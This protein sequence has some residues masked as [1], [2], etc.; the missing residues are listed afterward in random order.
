MLC[1]FQNVKNEFFFFSKKGKKMSK[2]FIL[3]KTEISYDP[4][5]YAT[6]VHRF[7]SAKEAVFYYISHCCPIEVLEG[8]YGCEWNVL[9]TL[10]VDN[11]EEVEEK[12]EKRLKYLEEANEMDNYL[13]DDKK[14][15]HCSKE[16]CYCDWKKFNHSSVPFEF[17]KNRGKIIRMLE[18]RD[19]FFNNNY[20]DDRHDIVDVIITCGKR[21]EQRDAIRITKNDIKV[22]NEQVKYLFDVKDIIQ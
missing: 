9:K 18:N 12:V 3:I 6:E 20:L 10:T 19:L 16:C 5:D 15:E 14:A 1:K 21:G 2:E 4:R 7:N 13:D 8:E 11:E 17:W 22:N